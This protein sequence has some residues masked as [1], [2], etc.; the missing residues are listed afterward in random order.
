MDSFLK[1]HLVPVLRSKLSKSNNGVLKSAAEDLKNFRSYAKRFSAEKGSRNDSFMKICREGLALEISEEEIMQESKRFIYG[2]FTENE[3]RSTYDSQ[4]RYN[5]D[6]KFKAFT[7]LEIPEENKN[8]E[9]ALNIIEKF[10]DLVTGLCTLLTLNGILHQYLEGFYKIVDEKIFLLELRRELNSNPAFKVSENKIQEV[11]RN[12][13]SE[14]MLK[15]EKM[16]NFFIGNECSNSF[17]ALK[18][19]VLDLSQILEN[20][21]IHY[22]LTPRFFCTGKLSFDHDPNATCPTF[23][24][25]LRRVLKDVEDQKQLQT[26]FAYHLL[27]SSKFGKLMVFIGE[28]AN[29]KSVVL[30]VLRLLLGEKNVSSVPIERLSNKDRFSAVETYGK[31]ANI[32]DEMS[33]DAIDEAFVK[34]YVTGGRIMVEKKYGNPFEF[35]PLA[36]LTFSTNSFPKIKDTTDGF[37]RRLLVLE[38]KEKIPPEEQRPEY[39]DDQFWIDSG[40]LAGVFNWVLEGVRYISENNRLFESGNSIRLTQQKRLSSNN[41]RQWAEENLSFK[42]GAYLDRQNAYRLYK[43]DMISQGEKFSTAADFYKEIEKVF[44]KSIHQKS[45]IAHQGVKRRGFHNIELATHGTDIF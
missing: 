28:G 36:K 19:S 23:F 44:P 24:S 7:K 2:D 32:S 6:K 21:I 15:T 9:V 29:G 10:K 31:L 12:I 27:S 41:A 33:G 35:Y 43:D 8:L 13:K 20:K 39:L 34:N 14:T 22:I 38:F 11:Y 4:V 5:R 25:I 42:V 30:K 37:W 45:A 26:W 1:D 16:N 18:S 17:I 40:E 3:A